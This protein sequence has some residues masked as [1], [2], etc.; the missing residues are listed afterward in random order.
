[1]REDRFAGEAEEKI[2]VY[3]C[4]ECGCPHTGHGLWWDSHAYS[5]TCAPCLGERI[6]ESLA[7]YLEEYPDAIPPQQ[8]GEVLKIALEGKGEDGVVLRVSLHDIKTGSAVTL[9]RMNIHDSLLDDGPH[10]AAREVA[11]KMEEAVVRA[12]RKLL[13]REIKSAWYD[14]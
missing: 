4:G 12:I 13:N 8:V 6:G 7:E 10:H 9:T 3:P 5:W 14:A 1:M 11:E 2:A